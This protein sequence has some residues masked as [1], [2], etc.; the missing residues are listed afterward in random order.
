MPLDLFPY[1]LEGARFLASRR[2][3]GLFDEPGAGKSG[4]LVH[5][6]DL[7][8]AVRILVVAPAAVREH[9]LRQFEL[10][11]GCERRICKGLT[12]HDFVAW[13]NNAFDVL[14]TSYEL[15][16][17][18]ARYIHEACDP[19]DAVIIDE[20]H[21]LKSATTARAKAIL[22]EGS[23]GRGGILQ[24]AV[25]A[26][27]ATG[28]PIPNDGLDIFTFLR[29]CRAMPLE[30]QAFVQRYFYVRQRTYSVSHTPSLEMLPELQALIGNNS[31]RRK[32]VDV[33]YQL[34]PIFL[35]NTY[36]DGD[37][38]EIIELLRMH[39]GLDKAIVEALEAGH[40]GK[41]QAEHV[42]TLR[43]LIGE[44]KAL[45]YAEMLLEELKGGLDKAVVFGVHRLALRQTADYLGR[46][47]IRCVLV[48]GDTPDRDLDPFIRAFQTE[49]SCR[50]F[51]GNIRKAGVGLTLTAAAALD[52][53]ESDWSPAGNAQAIKRVHRLTQTRSVRAR[54]ITLSHSFDEVV[55]A[56]VAAKTA[57]IAEIEGDPMLAMA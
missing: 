38:S 50:V 53:L 5:A 55:N 17:K 1:Q 40:I 11:Q 9:W 18:W 54:F 7:A 10:F 33:G 35:T 21:Y 44:A 27:W 37:A 57:T 14:I 3:A 2:R 15:A 32:L 24:W 29:F 41:I 51:I 26:W 49:A 20:G 47:G 4:Q 42:A 30:R 31:I 39:P 12:I 25:R 19:I 22:G 56:I 46:H 43:R 6:C 23:D 16:T 36:I 8:G 52:M 34:P 45:P 48:T 28:S 13:R